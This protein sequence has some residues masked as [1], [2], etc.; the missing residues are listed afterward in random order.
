MRLVPLERPTDAC[1]ALAIVEGPERVVISDFKLGAIYRVA[2]SL[3]WADR[4]R[5]Y[6]VGVSEPVVVALSAEALRERLGWVRVSEP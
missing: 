3:G 1:I 2:P 6:M 5:V 4:C